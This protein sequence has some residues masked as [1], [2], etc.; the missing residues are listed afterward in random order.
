MSEAGFLVLAL[1]TGLIVLLPSSAQAPAKLGYYHSTWRQAAGGRP[2]GKVFSG[3][4]QS[5]I[6]V[7]KHIST[8]QE[9]I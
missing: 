1:E 3:N 9:E 5:C 4:L 2:P 6:L 8:K 7:C